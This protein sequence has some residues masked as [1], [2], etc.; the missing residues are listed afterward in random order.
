MMLIASSVL[1]GTFLLTSMYLQD[2]LGTGRWRPG[3]R[4]CLIAIAPALGLTSESHLIGHAG[5]RGAGWHSRSSLIVVGTMLLS[6]PGAGGTT[7]QAYCP[8]WCRRTRS[9]HRAVG[10]ALSVLTGA[11][12]EE[13][14]MLSGVEHD[15][16]RGRRGSIGVAVMVS[17]ATGSAGAAPVALA[18]GIGDAF[19]VASIIATVG[20]IVGPLLLPTTRTFLPKL[21]AAPPVAVH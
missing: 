4:S 5:G 12:A 15:R 21:K 19:L 14:G 2:V 7:S 1:F 20:G 3:W 18:N 10:V 8:E 11:R 6:R 16:T 13:A 9:G 17:V